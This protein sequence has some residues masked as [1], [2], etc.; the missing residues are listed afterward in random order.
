MRERL[1]RAAGN[2]TASELAGQFI[3]I[4]ARFVL[5]FAQGD[6]ERR[7]VARRFR[8]LAGQGLHQVPDRPARRVTLLFLGQAVV[9]VFPGAPVLH[10]PCSLQLREMTGDARLAHAENAL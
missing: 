6:F 8:H 9:N 1:P 4:F 5:A 7:P 3:E 10:C 2:I